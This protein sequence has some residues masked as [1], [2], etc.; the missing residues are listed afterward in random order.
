MTQNDTSEEKSVRYAYSKLSDTW[1]RVHDWEHV[2]GNRIIANSKEE[3]A[4]EEVPQEWLDAT[5][6]RPLDATDPER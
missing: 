4:R 5:E 6:E 2:E 1:Y 3:V